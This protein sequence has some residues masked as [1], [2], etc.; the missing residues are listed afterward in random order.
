M[1]THGGQELAW[2]SWGTHGDGRESQC[3]GWVCLKTL[4][5]NPAATLE[6]G[7][8][9]TSRRSFDSP[10]PGR[11]LTTSSLRHKE[12]TS[13]PVNNCFFYISGTYSIILLVNFVNKS[14]AEVQ[15][16][17]TFKY[18]IL[19][20]DE[21]ICGV[22][23]RSL[24]SNHPGHWREVLPTSGWPVP[25]ELRITWFSRTVLLENTVCL[26]RDLAAKMK[27]LLEVS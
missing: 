7:V 27:L 15:Y 6:R 4:T 20:W 9:D 19:I 12:V 1:C 17:K 24:I 3:S 26:L 13:P 21:L 16:R 8:R 25:L 2:G 10:G 14:K 11:G 5:L 23:S 22:I 18:E